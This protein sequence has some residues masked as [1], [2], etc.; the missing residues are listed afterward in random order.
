VD[1]RLG[2]AAAAVHDRFWWPGVIGQQPPLDAARVC[3]VRPD[4]GRTVGLVQLRVSLCVRFGMSL[5]LIRPSFPMTCFES[6]GNSNSTATTF[7]GQRNHRTRP[8]RRVNKRPQGFAS[9]RKPLPPSSS[10]G[11]VCGSS[12]ALLGSSRHVDPLSTPH[13]V[14]RSR[15]TIFATSVSLNE[16]PIANGFQASPWAGVVYAPSG[17]TTTPDSASRQERDPQGSPVKRRGHLAASESL[18]EQQVTGHFPNNVSWLASHST[19]LL[20]GRLLA[21][22]W[23][24]FSGLERDVSIG[25]ILGSRR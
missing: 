20:T 1:R 21:C 16:S 4:A 3:L 7:T 14:R 17:I 11:C 15:R 18:T 13:K 23:G 5:S 24:A 8:F 2:C 10:P 9:Y 6:R 19:C 25:G 12:K 22:Y